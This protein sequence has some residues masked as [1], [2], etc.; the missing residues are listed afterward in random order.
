MDVLQQQAQLLRRFQREE[1]RRYLF[2][3]TLLFIL[4]IGLGAG[5]C[6]A[7]QEAGEAIVEQ[8]IEMATQ[9]GAMTEEGGISF[10]GI[11]PNNW[12]AMLLI[13]CYGLL[14]FLFLPALALFSNGALI[15]IMLSYYQ[16]H[17]LSVLLALAAIV[18]HG[19]FELPALVIAGAAGLCLCH[20]LTR[21]ILHSPQAPSLL[22]T[23]ENVLRLLLLTLFPLVL[24]AAIIET[25]ITPALLSLLI[26]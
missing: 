21:K 7:S 1:L 6:I 11:L 5:L 26:P 22:Q 25:Y 20:A 15:G 19:I 2:P 24:I 13:L 23:A 9:A 12:R 16:Q 18:P 14:P 3:S 8:F 10:F 4:S 17:G